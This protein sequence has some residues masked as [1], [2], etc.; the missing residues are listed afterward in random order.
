MAVEA[1]ACILCRKVRQHPYQGLSVK[2][3]YICAAC[4]ARI[5]AL[6]RDDP[7]YDHYKLGLKKIWYWQ[8]A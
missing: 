8:G 1:P 7:D 2:G 4:E 3:H 6:S 5:I